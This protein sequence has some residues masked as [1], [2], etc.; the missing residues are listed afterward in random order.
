MR[1]P[2]GQSDKEKMWEENKSGS[3]YGQSLKQSSDTHAFA[4]QF[5]IFLGK[6]GRRYP[7]AH[8]SDSENS[9]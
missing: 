5:V 4:T 6:E 7:Q 8:K 9:E 3:S 1:Q 2:Q